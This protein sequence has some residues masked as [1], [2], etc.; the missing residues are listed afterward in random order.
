MS[1]RRLNWRG[2]ATLIY[3]ILHI[4]CSLIPSTII[5]DTIIEEEPIEEPIIVETIKAIEPNVTTLKEV[6]ATYYYPGDPTGSGEW[7]GA[8]YHISRFQTNER[9]WFTFNNRVVLAAATNECLRS[10][11]G[12]CRDWN[13]PSSNITYYN[14]GDIVTFY[15]D[16]QIYEG[17]ILD[18]CGTSM[19]GHNKIDIFVSNNSS[20]YDGPMLLKEVR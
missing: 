12:P 17:I 8:G 5:V 18:T 15:I 3:L 20:G 13:T 4:T 10:Q 11:H 7:V 9:G 6:R 1:K 19:M 16:D 2:K 14:Y